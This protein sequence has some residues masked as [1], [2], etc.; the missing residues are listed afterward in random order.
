M[1]AFVFR[2]VLTLSPALW[3]RALVGA[4][5]SAFD[6]IV[7]AVNH[8]EITFISTSTSHLIFVDC[9]G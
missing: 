1:L 7:I 2:L 4:S 6:V 3:L 8:S 5:V 9:D